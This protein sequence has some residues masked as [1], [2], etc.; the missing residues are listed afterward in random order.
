MAQWPPTVVAPIP[1]SGATWPT[2]TEVGPVTLIGPTAENQ[3]PSAL[4]TRTE[5][6][7]NLLNTLVAINNV[8]RD[9]FLDRDGDDAA[10]E[11]SAQGPV[12]MRGRFD[13]GG[14]KIVNLA[15]GVS[16]QD[17]VTIQQLETVQ[18]SAEDDVE[19][20]LQSRVVFQ[21]GSA[22][23]I[24]TLS[25][26]G[27]RVIALDVA[28]V[29]T[30]ASRK[31]YADTQ[32]SALASA[33]VPLT[34]SGGM[35]GNLNMDGDDPL[36]DGFKIINCTDPTASGNIVNKRYLDE[37]VGLIAV[38]DVPIGAVLSF[39]GPPS[40]IPT[41]FLICDGREVSR[42]TYQN[43]FN[44][45]GIAYGPPSSGSVF[46]L[47]DLRG[48]TIV[49][50]DSMGGQSADVITGSWADSLGGK[51]G[52]ERHQLAPAEMPAH[53][54]SYDDISYAYDLGGVEQ[55]DVGNSP[56]GSWQYDSTTRNTNVNGGGVAH[57]NT[58]PSMFFNWI[59]RA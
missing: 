41:K 50:R 1:D 27:N 51:Y 45:I 16:A 18:F 48:R 26:G 38:E 11:G 55:G 56:A 13:M 47:P 20:V 44:I 6:L 9:H 25:A 43:L 59:I 8:I 12:Y 2:R 15:D 52:T 33:L 7:R 36:E 3:Q 53:T 31:D 57:P 39:A 29:S 19:Q 30:D 46:R 24:A 23:M 4:G 40:E 54:H 21:D 17:A 49:G 22:A 34:G 10:I 42:F 37:Q 28:L 58:Q 32:T 14:S 35:T 5:S